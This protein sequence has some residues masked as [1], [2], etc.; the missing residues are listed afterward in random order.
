MERYCYLVFGRYI[1][2]LDIHMYENRNNKNVQG[3]TYQYYWYW[4]IGTFISLYI[5]V[6]IIDHVLG[7]RQ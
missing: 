2:S 4:S 3:V 1:E 7:Q 5:Q 6:K